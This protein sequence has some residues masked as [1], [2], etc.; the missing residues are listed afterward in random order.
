MP[1]SSRDGNDGCHQNTLARAVSPADSLPSASPTIVDIN[2]SA[3]VTSLASSADKYWPIQGE[4]VERPSLLNRWRC[5]NSVLSLAATKEW[6]IAGTGSGEILVFN[7]DTL[8]TEWVFKGHSGSVYSLSVTSDERFLFSGA[9]DSLV[10]AWDLKQ[11]KEIYTIYSRADIGDVFSI[12]WAPAHEC[13]FLGAQNASI[14]WIQLYEKESYQTTEDPSGLPSLR[15]N[16]FFDSKGPGGRVVPEQAK[17]RGKHTGTSMYEIPPQNMI[18]YAHYG[19]VYSLLVIKR[20]N[21]AQCTNEEYLVS[22]GGDGTVKIWNFQDKKLTPLYTF[23]TDSSVFSLC[24]EDSFLYCGLAKGQ[25]Y[26]YD[27]DTRQNV[28]VDQAG[29]DDVMAMSLYHECLFHSSNGAVQKWDSKRYHR[30]QWQAHDGL[31]LATVFTE[32]NGRKLLV[33]GGNDTSV[34]MWDV[35]FIVDKYPAKSADVVLAAFNSTQALKLLE[36]A[37][38]NLCISKQ[39]QDTNT[40]HRDSSQVAT[41]TLDHMMDTLRDFI[42]YKTIS[43]HEGIHAND[44]RRCATFLRNLFRHFGADS[45]LLPVENGG[46]PI[47]YAKFEGTKSTASRARAQSTA[48]SA[49][50]AVNSPTLVAQQEAEAKGKPK[51]KARILFYGHYDVID[52]DKTEDWDTDPF[53]MTNVDG[54]MYGRGVSDNKGPILAALFAVAELVQRSELECDVVFIIEGEEE[55]GSTGFQEAILKHKQL[56][57]PIDWVLLSNSYW[58]D[59]QTPCLN[60]GLRGVI[61]AEVEVSGQQPDLHSGVYGGVYREPTFDLVNLVSKL[62]SDSGEILVPH[63]SDAVRPV[64]ADEERL[65]TA[66]DRRLRHD[67][68]FTAAALM[69]RWR[70]PSFSIHRIAVS[71]PGNST[72]IPQVA[73]AVLSLRIVPDQDMAVIQKHLLAHLEAQFAQFATPNTLA[74]R[75]THSSEPWV[76]NPQ[77]RAFKVLASAVQDVWGQKPLFIREGGSIPSV[78]FL[79]RT[80]GAEAA[81]LPVGQA[82][83][84]AHLSN[85]RLRVVNF[86]GARDVF[87]KV[88]GGLA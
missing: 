42:S 24:C 66:I 12:A 67:G 14:Q 21:E 78:R 82:S 80:F 79:E 7:K 51:R 71:G 50:A 5:S 56:I 84:G 37:I 23:D 32:L 81:Q 46:N 17:S 38:Q 29:Q 64:T 27:L 9:A 73:T 86:S 4:A 75:V 47:V 1:T 13:L 8:A 52:A 53:N 72:L 15:F 62:A 30:G 40:E 28:R 70:F 48:N 83:D 61:K 22:G 41:F 36:P 31:L 26:M 54:Y 33:T 2:S 68:Q 76:G 25:V 87:L 49:T 39:A 34:C 35:S 59:D 65:Y 55:S 16:R 44:C 19:Y 77:N 18:Q 45:Q 60:Y 20:A 74:V 58:L 63:F 6:V 43:G 57:G 11:R 85:E 3:D 69:T 10:K 88:F